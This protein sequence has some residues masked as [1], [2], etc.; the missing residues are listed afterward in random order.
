M[1]KSLLLGTYVN[2]PYHPLTGIDTLL[3]K[4][5]GDAF[6]VESTDNP[7]AF[8]KLSAETDLVI[9]YLDD[10]SSPIPE[11]DAE[12]LTQYVS[13]GGGLL[14]IHNGISLQQSPDLACLIG[15]R[16]S[17]HPAQEPVTFQSIPGTFLEGCEEFTI[18]EEPYQF[19]DL[20]DIT[21]VLSYFYHG[22]AF[23]GGW[24]KTCGRGRIVY[25]CPGHTIATFEVPSF[26]KMI[27]LGALRCARNA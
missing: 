14:V 2:P 12:A 16:F 1:K 21:P 25:L 18:S 11:R 23:L 13:E 3:T 20:G 22:E 26:Q 15:G 27:R 10:W 6:S 9:S 8:Q 17:H 7:D 24:E 5:L 4:L 19:T